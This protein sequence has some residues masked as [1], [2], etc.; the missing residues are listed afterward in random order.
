MS[1]GDLAKRHS[2]RK[3]H[4]NRKP[5]MA[6]MAIMLGLFHRFSAF[7]ARLNGRRT[8]A[9][10]QARRKRL[11]LQLRLRHMAA[12]ANVG[13]M[14]NAPNDVHLGAPPLECVPLA[15]RPLLTVLGAPAA[16]E[17]RLGNAHL[18]VLMRF[19]VRPEE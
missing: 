2:H 7:G 18:A 17:E 11:L 19:V 4:G 3:K 5:P 16:V 13:P 15:R 6:S 10:D 12:S 9:Q 1:M 8:R 14:G